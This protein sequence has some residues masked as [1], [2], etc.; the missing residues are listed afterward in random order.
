MKKKIDLQIYFVTIPSI[1]FNFITFS[2]R[3]DYRHILQ[4]SDQL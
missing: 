4:I 1:K 3:Q 2:T